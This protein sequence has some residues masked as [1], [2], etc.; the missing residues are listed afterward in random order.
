[1][2]SNAVDSNEYQ[3]FLDQ[4]QYTETGVKRY[5]WI[6]GDEYL[7]TGGLQTTKEIVPRL[8]LKPGQRVLDIGSGLGGHDFYMA[9][10]YGVYIDAV[11]L[12]KNMM[13]IA[14][15]YH[16]QK[17]AIKDRI[18]FRLCDVMTTDFPEA[19]YD[20][21]YSRDALLHIKD[22]P[23]LFAKFFKWL[24]PGGRVVFTDYIRGDGQLSEEF[25]EYMRQRDYTLFTR[26]QYLDCFKGAGF[27][28]I[29][30]DEIKDKF[31]ASLQREL[32]QLRDGR[33]DFLSKFS[34]KDYDDLEQGWLAK[35]KRAADNDQSWVLAAGFKPAN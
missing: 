29:V 21:V 14:M 2:G 15:A 20:V 7:S 1:M 16:A 23:A 6:F 19:Y 35:I 34:Q 30:V 13:D 26:Q 33:A 28:R 32:K 24:K 22:K 4:V 18:N 31:V 5:E 10:E 12:S 27:E 17:P 25:L 3:K 11:D 8:E 9:A